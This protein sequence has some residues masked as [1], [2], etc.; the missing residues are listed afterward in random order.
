MQSFQQWVSQ[1]SCL[2]AFVTMG[3]PGPSSRPPEDVPRPLNLPSQQDH[4][5]V[6]KAVAH[7][8]KLF[9]KLAILARNAPPAEAPPSTPAPPDPPSSVPPATPPA[10]P[11]WWARTWDDT[12]KG[13]KKDYERNF[14]KFFSSVEYDPRLGRLTESTDDALSSAIESLKAAVIGQMRAVGPPS[15]VVNTGDRPTTPDAAAQQPGD[16]SAD[17]AVPP[18]RTK[19]TPEER[20]KRSAERRQ[21]R[22][23]AKE[24]GKVQADLDDR[25]AAQAKD[26]NSDAAEYNVREIHN[27]YTIYREK[28]LILLSPEG[29]QKFVFDIADQSQL[30]Q[31]LRRAEEDRKFEIR[32]YNNVN[33]KPGNRIRHRET[34][35]ID[36]ENS[37]RRA[38]QG[39]KD[40][41][42]YGFRNRTQQRKDATN[43][44]QDPTGVD[45]W[46]KRKDS[47]PPEESPPTAFTHKF[48]KDKAGQSVDGPPIGFAPEEPLKK[49]KGRRR[50][51]KS[52][53]FI[54]RFEEWSLEPD[55]RCRF[56]RRLL[57]GN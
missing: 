24:Y 30:N 43:D 34:V 19:L 38:I 10:K 35:V 7:V 26:F 32:I 29:S 2:E 14:G 54:P 12:K 13:W 53:H 23:S 6:A 3:G 21:A 47:V 25:K 22:T 8:E 50:R 33:G 11:G 37:V 42:A 18:G 16:K 51:P 45:K 48:D 52:E 56:V 1:N 9:E 15:P 20:Q 46:A 31:I 57:S 36:D 40:A 44:D 39:I 41:I 5:A 27:L 55:I 4:P 17:R 28:Y 49:K